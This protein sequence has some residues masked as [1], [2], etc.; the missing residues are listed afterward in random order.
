MTSRSLYSLQFKT[1][2]NFETNLSKL[3]SLILK[4]ENNSIILA[5][6]VCLSGFYY[7][8]MRSASIF[9]LQAIKKLKVLSINKI[10]ALTMIEEKESN[11]YNTLFV[12][13]NGEIVYKQSKVELFTIGGEI[14]N[15][16]KISIPFKIFEIDGI[17]FGAL[18][19]FELRFINHWQELRGADIILVPAM[20]GKSRKKHFEQLNSA[21][22][23][24]NQCYVIASD[25]SNEDMAKSSAIITPFG[26]IKSGDTKELLQYEFKNSEIKKM[27]RYIDVGIQYG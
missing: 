3:E 1:T 26:D 22:A 10:I 14:E 4:C 25:S 11:Y 20:W 13:F 2:S 19:C 17:K 27:R 15:F 16:K 23:I 21:L 7:E 5:P 8:D 12:F 9:T 24:A 6:E 18:I